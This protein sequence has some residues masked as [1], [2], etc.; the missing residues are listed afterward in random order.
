MCYCRFA[1]A[2]N[3]TEL[4]EEALGHAQANWNVVANGDELLELPLAQLITLL[5][6]EH[7]KVDS[8]SQ[9]NIYKY[10]ISKGNSARNA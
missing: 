4:A 3:C 1:E 7:L 2:H 9:V 5:S 10:I 6:S 8:E